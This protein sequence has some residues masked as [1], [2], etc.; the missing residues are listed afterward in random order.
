MVYWFILYNIMNAPNFIS[1]GSFFVFRTFYPGFFS[2]QD[3]NGNS[4]SEEEI[5]SE[6]MTFMF[7]GHDTTASCK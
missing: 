4:L 2:Y 1:W 7:A 3:E 6:V 5:T